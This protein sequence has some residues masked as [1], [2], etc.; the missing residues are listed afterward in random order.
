MQ[1]QISSMQDIKLTPLQRRELDKKA[2]DALQKGRQKVAQNQRAKRL[3][4]IKSYRGLRHA[5]GL[6]TRGQRTR[7]HFRK[8]KA[9][10][11]GIRKKGK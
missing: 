7:S 11:A 10:G 1:L 2:F 8:E 6:P 9:K 3:K 4:K 5:A